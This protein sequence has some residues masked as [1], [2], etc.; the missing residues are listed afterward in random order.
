MTSIIKVL[1]VLIVVIV[2]LLSITSFIYYT[3][4]ESISFTNTLIAV[5][6]GILLI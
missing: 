1:L 5:I 6:S 3:S 2:I 4:N